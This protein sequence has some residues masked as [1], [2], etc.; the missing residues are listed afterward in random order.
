M[1]HIA[2]YIIDDST[3]KW[4]EDKGKF[5]QIDEDNKKVLLTKVHMAQVLG[6]KWDTFYDVP[7]CEKE[8][9]TFKV[10]R[11]VPIYDWISLDLYGYGDTESMAW[12]DV[13]TLYEELDA[14]NIRIEENIKLNKEKQMQRI[15]RFALLPKNRTLSDFRNIEEYYTDMDLVFFKDGTEDFRNLLVAEGIPNDGRASDC[16]TGYIDDKNVVFMKDGFVKGESEFYLKAINEKR[17]EIVKHY[18]L[19]DPVIYM[20]VKRY[21]ETLLDENNITKDIILSGSFDYYYPKFPEKVINKEGDS[22]DER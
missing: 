10:I 4:V 19:N 13:K 2:D 6:T 1:K 20:G 21:Y 8:G 16:V 14:L 7:E 18:N 5:Y 12:E 15:H 17:E 22:I 3:Y 9:D 11:S